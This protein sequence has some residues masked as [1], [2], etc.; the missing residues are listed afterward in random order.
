MKDLNSHVKGGKIHLKS[1]PGAKSSQ[2]NYF[3]KSAL[4]EYK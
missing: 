3:I 4:E 1:F 2:L